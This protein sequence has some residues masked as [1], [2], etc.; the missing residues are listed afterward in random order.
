MPIDLTTPALLFPAISLLMLAYTNRF[1]AVAAIIR[2]LHA[3]YLSHPNPLH[4]REIENLRYRIRL[5]RN[6]QFCGVLSL[7]LCVVCMFFLF[8]GWSRAG[9]FVFMASLI[10]MITSLFISLREIQMSVQALDLH[11]QNL[12]EPVPGDQPADTPS[13]REIR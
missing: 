7:L 12:E 9:E 3:G 1:L 13:S 4:L 6:M 10:G 8:R 5:I 11:I 2:S